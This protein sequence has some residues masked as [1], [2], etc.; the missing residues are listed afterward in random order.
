M[1]A[2]ACR[3]TSSRLPP[4]ACRSSLTGES[5]S[6]WLSSW[7]SSCCGAGRSW[8]GPRTAAGGIHNVNAR[9]Q[10]LLLAT[11]GMLIVSGI[12]APN[13]RAAPA[14]TLS[15][16]SPSPN[17][18]I[19]NGSPVVVVFAVTNFN[20]TDSRNGTSS[21]DSGHVDVFVDGGWTAKASINTIVLALPSGPHTIRLRPRTEHR[22]A[23]NPDVTAS[24]AVVMTQGPPGGTP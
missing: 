3:F 21:P 7:S 10:A 12:A 17:A 9:M 18:V 1:R 8:A 16:V 11:V 2:R 23:L 24:V 14:P 15:I 19:G 6:S 20:L 13:V 22:A 5:R 4:S